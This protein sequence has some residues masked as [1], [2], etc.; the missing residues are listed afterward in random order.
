[1]PKYFRQSKLTSFQRQLNLYG[2]SRLTSGKDRGGYYH[3]MFLRH[4]LFL[5]QSMTRIRIKGTGIKGKASPETE[6]DFYSMPMLV[7]DADT[8]NKANI[9]EIVAT[10]IEEN[11]NTPF[12]RSYKPKRIKEDASA[13]EA[14]F[15]SNNA[16]SPKVEQKAFV[17][18]VVEAAIESTKC[19]SPKVGKEAFVPPAFVTPDTQR[20]V[21]SISF[22]ASFPLA[23]SSA[24]AA[25]P[26]QKRA[27]FRLQS[28]SF[29]NFGH[30]NT[31]RKPPFISSDSGNS[32]SW[33]I[34]PHDDDTMV[35]EGKQFHYLDSL[36]SHE[37]EDMAFHQRQAPGHMQR[38]PSLTPIQTHDIGST[39]FTLAQASRTASSLSLPHLISSLQSSETDS[40]GIQSP[41]LS[42]SSSSSSICGMASHYEEHLEFGNPD[43]IFSCESPVVDWDISEGVD[44]DAEFSLMNQK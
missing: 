28:R 23:F 26:S 34:P 31:E 9:E 12:N 4:K 20:S 11:K 17:P 27:S 36:A 22:P 19:T 42:P 3:E 5:C 38:A 44:I 15:D 24:A 43:T 16:T 1:M 13:S 29:R 21:T 37:Y 10:A 7:P 14:A 35:F 39:S 8:T 41:I 32:S 25:A 33:H 2:F 40:F 18:P 30:E 6:P